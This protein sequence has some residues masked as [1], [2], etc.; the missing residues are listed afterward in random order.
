MRLFYAFERREAC[1]EPSHL[2]NLSAQDYHLEATPGVYVHM[3]RADYDATEVVLKFGKRANGI[4][5]VVVVYYRDSAEY[6]TAPFLPLRLGDI[7]S[8]DLAHRLGAIVHAQPRK[9]AIELL[10]Q[11]LWDRNAEADQVFHDKTSFYYL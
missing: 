4:V 11:L 9:P 2:F 5:T 6:F 1:D 7:A 3:R 10:K 8:Y